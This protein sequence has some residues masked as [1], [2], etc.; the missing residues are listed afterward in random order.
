MKGGEISSTD[1]GDIYLE[2]ERRCS[3]D[4]KIGPPAGTKEIGVHKTG[5]SAGIEGQREKW[6][7][8]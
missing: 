1:E 8:H 7:E 5:Y 4:E 6:I 2:R 3:V